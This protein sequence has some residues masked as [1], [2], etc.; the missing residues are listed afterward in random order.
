[1]PNQNLRSE[2]PLRIFFSKGET[3]KGE[4]DAV[5]YGVVS[6]LFSPLCFPLRIPFPV[7]SHLPP[8]LNILCRRQNSARRSSTMARC[9]TTCDL[10]NSLAD[11]FVRYGL[12]CDISDFP[13][14]QVTAR[15]DTKVA[16]TTNE[17]AT[18]KRAAA[19]ANS[20]LY[21]Q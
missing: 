4:Q 10:R 13:T 14:S 21:F 18:D 16:V 8:P 2:A 1:M 5:P 17:Y 12:I 11:S 9:Y 3:H 6:G 19:A 7:T 15:S 20:D